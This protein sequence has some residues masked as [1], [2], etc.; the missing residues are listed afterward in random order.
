MHPRAFEKRRGL[1]SFWRELA[2]VPD[3]YASLPLLPGARRLFEAVR[4]LDP[5]I[6]TGCPR[7]GWA[8]A[9]KVRWAAEHFPGTRIITCMAVDKRRHGLRGDVLVDDTLKHR[10]LWEAMGGT[11][12]HHHDVSA[13][14]DVLRGLGLDVRDPV[15]RL[16]AATAFPSAADLRQAVEG[17]GTF[18]PGKRLFH[19]YPPGSLEEESIMAQNNQQGSNQHQNPGQQ[20]QQDG[21]RQNQ[22]GQNP[23][24]VGGQQEQQD[25]QRRQPGQDN[26]QGN[27]NNQAG[28]DDEN[29]QN[30]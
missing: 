7:C 6:L 10:H 14:L 26:D 20:E 8:E 3:F 24:K 13:T 2:R 9:Q 15:A 18:S 5:V 16:E 30:R 22:Q 4:H 21:Q 17:G 12:V 27:K 11:F 19:A 29:R 28:R 23:G 1:P 25:Q